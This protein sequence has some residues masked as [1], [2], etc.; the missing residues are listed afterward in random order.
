MKRL[1]L[2]VVALALAF[3]AGVASAQTTPSPG[4]WGL[5]FHHVDA[6]IGIRWWLN[7]K[8]ALDAGIGVGS[9]E[10]PAVDENLSHWAL[11]L[12]VPILLR[13]FDR[14]NFLVRPG[15]MFQSQEVV[16]DPGPPVDTDNDTFMSVGVE[17][18]AEVFLTDRFSVSASHGFAFVNADPA[19]GSS[20]TDWGT[21]GANF[22]NIG[23][24]VYLSERR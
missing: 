7:D 9:D 17:L 3:T 8:V 1:L 14:L 22:T 23:F 2:G 15:I 24:H 10:A 20:T 6:P 16:V 11:D 18:E 21:T 12:G 13:S 5:G 4:T 19:V